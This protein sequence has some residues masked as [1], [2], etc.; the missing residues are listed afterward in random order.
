MTAPLVAPRPYP[1]CG[2]C[3]SL[4][5]EWAAVTEP[6]SPEHD[7]DRANRLAVDMGVHRRLDEAAE[8]AL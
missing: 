3:T 4:M 2:H 5:R 8:P 6:A 7:R 1:G